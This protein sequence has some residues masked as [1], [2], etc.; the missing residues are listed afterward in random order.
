MEKILPSAWS[1][2]RGNSLS[3][4]FMGNVEVDTKRPEIISV[5]SVPSGRYRTGVFDCIDDTNGTF[6]APIEAFEGRHHYDHGFEW[7]LQ[8]EKRLVR[9]VSSEFDVLRCCIVH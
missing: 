1:R 9:K 2:K 5:H 3:Q 8:E 7:E 4:P 6:Y